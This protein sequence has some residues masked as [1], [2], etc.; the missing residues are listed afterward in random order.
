MNILLA[1]GSSDSRHAAQAEAL[2]AAASKELGEAIELRFLSNERLPDEA[3]VLPLLLGEGWHAKIDLARL[4]RQPGC[5]MLPALSEHPDAIAGMAGELAVGARDEKANA[6]FGVYHFAGFEAVTTA[7]YG[8]KRKFPRVALAALYSDPKLADV[9]SLLAEE[10]VK[11][12]VVQP[13]AVFEG[14]TME[15]V[16]R[17]VAGSGVDAAVGPVLSEHP[18][19]AGF[20]ADCFRRAK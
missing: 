11:H 1:H 14:R 12:L 5:T 19:F 17:V 6:L 4:S 2:A 20:V 8:L 3:R 15:H 7:L 9:L 18:G 16:R 10:K 13:L